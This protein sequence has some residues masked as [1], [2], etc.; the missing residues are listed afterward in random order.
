MRKQREVLEDISHVAATNGQIDVSPGIKQHYRSNPDRAR[1]RRG[2]SRN[3]I[4]QRSLSGA[5]RTKENRK[6][7]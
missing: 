3:A 5:R 7:P 4:E 6:A 2:E 1:I